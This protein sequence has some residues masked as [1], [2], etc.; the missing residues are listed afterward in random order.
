M[1]G[2]FGAAFERICQR[3]FFLQDLRRRSMPP[4]IALQVYASGGSS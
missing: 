4:T 1:D 3:C 2:S